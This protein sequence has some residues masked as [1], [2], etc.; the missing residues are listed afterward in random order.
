MDCPH[1]HG[2]LAPIKQASNSMQIKGYY[3]SVCHYWEDAKSEE[4][5]HV[6]SSTA[7]DRADAPAS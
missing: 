4:G 1:N 5:N 3:C 2:P 6:S 7:E